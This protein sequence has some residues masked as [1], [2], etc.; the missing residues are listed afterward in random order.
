MTKVVIIGDCWGREEAENRLPFVG[1]A[2]KLLRATLAQ[3]GID[4]RE[5][6]FTNVINQRPVTVTSGFRFF[7]G[8]K[9][10]AIP[11]RAAVF[12]P[13]EYLKADYEPELDRLEN[14]LDRLRPNLIIALGSTPLW[15][16]T[17]NSNLKK[18]RGTPVSTPWGK[19]IPIHRP[20]NILADM[21]LRP[22]FLNDL[23]KCAR[24]K[25]FPEICR[26]SREL[27][28]EPTLSDLALF[29]EKIQAASEIACDIET[30]GRSIT[31]IGFST[32]DKCAICIPFFTTKTIDNN[33]WPTPLDEFRA[34]RWV[35]RWLQHPCLVGQN[36]MYDM[37]F[38]WSKMGFK[39]GP[40]V[41]DTMLMHHALFPGMEKS[42]AFLGSSYTNEPSWKFM[43]KTKTKKKED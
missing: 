8:P 39:I 19:C 24:E 15:F 13:S 2:G 34:W 35:R 36:F 27:W 41:N 21:S 26:P 37:K 42:L 43:R 12:H 9:E 20:E 31:C 29:D 17:N 5:V 16:L 7:C 1:A 14:E 32:S 18:V 22:V 25:E 23:R 10:E 6:Y 33:Y 11:D 28:L 38:L 4:S 3:V 40:N 30:F